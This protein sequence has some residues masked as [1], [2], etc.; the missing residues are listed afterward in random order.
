[1]GKNRP[2]RDVMGL[3]IPRSGIIGD[4]HFAVVV[5]V[6]PLAQRDRLRGVIVNVPHIV[7]SSV[8][9]FTRWS[10]AC[11]ARATL[12]DRHGLA[13]GIGRWEDIG[14]RVMHYRF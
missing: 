8:T 4:S 13:E 11:W 14:R 12:G 6:C 10:V 3:D 2:E 9:I 7:F 1:M 5:H